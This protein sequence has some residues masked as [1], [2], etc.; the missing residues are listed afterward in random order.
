MRIKISF[1]LYIFSFKQVKFH[2]VGKDFLHY[3]LFIILSKF[4]HWKFER[5][6][7]CQLAM[8]AFFLFLQGKKQK[9]LCL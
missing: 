7:Y 6:N 3:F 5:C 1:K 2:P 8:L 9:S 4:S